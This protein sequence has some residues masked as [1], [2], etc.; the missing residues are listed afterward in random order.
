MHLLVV[1]DNVRLARSLARLL[2]EDHHVV[3]LAMTGH[4]GLELAVGADGLDVV[5][6]DIGLPDIDGLQ[7][8]RSLRAEG[9]TLPILMLTA[10]DAVGDRVAGLDAGADDYLVKPFA[11]P[12]LSARLRAL[13]RR[14]DAERTRHEPAL[15][16]GSIVLD[17]AARQVHVAEDSLELSQRE[18]ALLECLMRHPDQVLTRDQL[19]DHAWPMAVAVM[20][21]TVD[22]YVSFLRRKLGP[23]SERIQ[24][25]RGVGYRMTST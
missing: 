18:F 20:P 3:E 24:T 12:E 17:E 25:V 5:I 2:V 21:N 23:E 15:R 19:L 8:C 4:E 10:R 16:L 22:Q 1:E 7:V 6:L 9:L 14:G 11:Y 13:G